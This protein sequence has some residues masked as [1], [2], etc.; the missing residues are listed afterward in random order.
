MNDTITLDLIILLSLG[1]LA[2]W[3][4]WKLKLPPILVLLSA[5]LIVGPVLNFF[6]PGELLGDSLF[7]VVSIAVSVILFEGGLTL[8][9]GD[10]KYGGKVIFR[11]VSV[12]V[13]I[14][15]V[16]TALAAHYI[17]GF[18]LEESFLYGGLL[19]VTGPT[20]IGPMLRTI[21][22]NGNI[23]KIAK[24]EGILNDPVGV[25]IAV[26]VY[27][28]ITLGGMNEA[29]QAVLLAFGKV[30]VIGAGLAFLGAGITILLVRQRLL[31]E[32]LHN[33][34]L[35]VLVI[36]SF[37]FANN[38]QEESGLV[39]V[40]LL[41]ILLAN[42]KIFLVDHILLF[43]E[44]LRVL[45]IS[46]LFIILSAHID[47]STLEVLGYPSIV[48][49]LVLILLVRPLSV[50]G[51]TLLS[52]TPWK[53]RFLLMMLAPRGIVALSLSSVFA[54]KLST[55][56]Y[57]HGEE[58]LAVTML[59]I[60][61]TI[62]FYGFG[63]GWVAERLGLSERD[64]QGI[65]FIGAH[66]WARQLA[67]LLQDNGVRVLLVDSNTY[68]I[69][70]CKKFSLEA[71]CGSVLSKETLENLDLS[72]IGH[73]VCITANHKINAFA[74]KNLIEYLERPDVY[75]ISPEQNTKSD[76]EYAIPLNPLFG[77]Q[78]TYN[79][80]HERVTKGSSF[81]CLLLENYSDVSKH[82]LLNNTGNTPMFLVNQQGKV[83]VFSEMESPPLLSNCKVFYLRDP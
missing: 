82:S 74:P 69:E 53:E 71:Y 22:P 64:P 78:V 68:N 79:N 67:K 65:L 58:M 33:I 13:A 60:L 73:A 62:I 54:M 43:K 35:L 7:P 75:C 30:L 80:I 3:L 25:L 18:T 24:W 52:T 23:T 21:R 81:S 76:A 32:F 8:K 9:I 29:P 4:G 50:L 20:V 83:R 34:F 37:F 39:T 57:P 77:K 70:L 14:T 12:G 59:V 36:G 27:E 45:F 1:V 47:F 31:P 55:K 10:L 61:G 46:C 11:L 42:Q 6:N 48:F 16:T 5:G 15:C 56:G 38:F 40:T 63:A 72:R 44:N 51:S 28:I 49:L 26:F 41:G 2:Q 17:L 66:L 19:S